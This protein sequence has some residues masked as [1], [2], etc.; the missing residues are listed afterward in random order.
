[1]NLCFKNSD[2]VFLFHPQATNYNGVCQA[3]RITER[4]VTASLTANLE[5]VTFTDP[6][7]N[8]FSFVN[9]EAVAR[10]RFNNIIPGVFGGANYDQVLLSC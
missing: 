7:N 2:S 4:G 1:M 10:Y 6:V 9:R 8:T 5:A 3:Y